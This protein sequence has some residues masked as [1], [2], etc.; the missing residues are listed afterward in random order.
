VRG[1]GGDEVYVADEPRVSYLVVESADVDWR[2]ELFE[3]V[4][5][6]TRPAGSAARPGG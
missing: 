6:A 4:P 5:A 3:R 1:G 2:I